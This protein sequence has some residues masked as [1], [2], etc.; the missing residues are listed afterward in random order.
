MN[1][2]VLGGGCSRCETLLRSAKQ[3]AANLGIEAEFEYI[4][5]MARIAEY[6]IMG[7]PALVIDGK[8]VSAGKVLKGAE[9]EKFLK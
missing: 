9:I 7:L 2:K 4:T 5:D 3:A 1:I 8:V 6:G